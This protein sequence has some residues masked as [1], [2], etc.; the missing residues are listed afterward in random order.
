MLSMSPG[1]KKNFSLE[2]I[3]SSSM[4]STQSKY[5]TYLEQRVVLMHEMLAAF[6]GAPIPP[7]TVG[8]MQLETWAVLCQVFLS[9]SMLFCVAVSCRGGGL[10]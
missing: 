2:D 8:L 9:A 7:F 10:S 1:K 4:Q 3:F 5:Y 6:P